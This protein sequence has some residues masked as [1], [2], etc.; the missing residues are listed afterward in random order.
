[1]LVWEGV[2]SL[3]V[4]YWDLG[5]RSA[6]WEHSLVEVVVQCEEVLVPCSP[7]QKGSACVWQC[8]KYVV[9]ELLLQREQGG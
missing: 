3:L 4:S 6:N 8:L 2:T 1:M 7:H 9:L 5:T